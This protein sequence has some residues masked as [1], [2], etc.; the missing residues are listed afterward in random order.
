[1]SGWYISLNFILTKISRKKDMLSLSLSLS[2]SFTQSFKIYLS[3]IILVFLLKKK[4]N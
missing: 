2:L 4:T 3:Y 1:M